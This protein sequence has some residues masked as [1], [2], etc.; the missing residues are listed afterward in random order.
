MKELKELISLAAGVL[1]IAGCIYGCD[2][3]KAAEGS[4]FVGGIC[5]IGLSVFV[6]AIVA[7]IIKDD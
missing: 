6:F 5:V 3:M 2:M 4:S 1:C 7:K